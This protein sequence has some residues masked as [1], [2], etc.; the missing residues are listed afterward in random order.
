MRRAIGGKEVRRALFLLVL[1]I[2]AVAAPAASVIV[3][4]KDKLERIA[5][6]LL[7]YETLDAEDVKLILAGAPLNKPTVGELLAA[8]QAKVQ[9]PTPEGQYEKQE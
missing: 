7:K 6:A 4:N 1:V 2:P 8:E 3:D 5:R 9:E